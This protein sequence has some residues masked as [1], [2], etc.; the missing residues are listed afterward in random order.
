MIASIKAWSLRLMEKPRQLFL[1]DGAGALLSAFLLGVVLVKLEHFFGI[2][3]SALY[4]LA[5]I[6]V[7]FAIYDF[8]CYK[9]LSSHFSPYLKIIATLNIT[10]C[11]LSIGYGIFHSSVITPVGW[12][13]I[14]LE[15]LI[16]MFI[17]WLEIK[18]ASMVNTNKAL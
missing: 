5:S 3:P 8:T 17:A 16:V 1:I 7:F 4:V 6:P 11:G 18:A 2:P 13:Y 15:V 12:V 14:I 10:Y 9:T